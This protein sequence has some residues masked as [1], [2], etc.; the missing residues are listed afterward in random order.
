ML[1]ANFKAKLGD[2]GLARVIES[3]RNSHNTENVGGTL[4]YMAPEYVQDGRASPASDVYGFGVLMLEVICQRMP[5][6]RINGTDGLISWVR[7]LSQE[8]RILDAVDQSLYGNDDREEAKEFLNL[9]LRC[10]DHERERRPRT[11]EIF[12]ELDR[13]AGNDPSFM[14]AISE[15]SSMAANHDVETTPR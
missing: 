2:F 9:G 14:S 11:R 6:D 10:C 1:D 13:D 3:G 12:R 15:E 8:N 5:I 7:N 4:G